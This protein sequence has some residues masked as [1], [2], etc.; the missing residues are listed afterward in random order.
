MDIRKT[1]LF[2][3]MQE[4][5]NYS[6]DDHIV[7]VILELRDEV[8]AGGD[9]EELLYDEGFEPDYVFDILGD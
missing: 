9:P 7:E 5:G 3:A 1:D 2:K 4:C 6:D 8:L